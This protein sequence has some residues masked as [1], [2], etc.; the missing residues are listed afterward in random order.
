MPSLEVF[1]ISRFMI[2]TLVL[3][4]ISA[5]VMTA[6]LFGSQVLPRRVRALLA[7]A[8]SLLVTPVYL[9]TT[10]PPVE[11]ITQY[12]RLL[13]NEVLVGLLLG[14]GLNILFSGIQV[15]GQVVSQ[16][17]GLSLADVFNPGIEEDAS[18]FSQLFYFLTMAV[19]VAIGGH[20]ILTEA[21]LETFAAAPPGHA[22]LGAGFLDVLTGILTQSFA[23][24]ISA[25]APL[26][27]A[28][29]LS[30][31]ILGLVS[32]TLPQINVIAVGFGLNSLLAMGLLSVSLG[33]VAYTFQ[34]PTLD[35]LEKI[36]ATVGN[37]ATQ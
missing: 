37:V 9:G 24:G 29:L 23:L 25:A 26:L 7:V 18:V 5:V 27:V 16:M 35:V 8:L 12:G 22:V 13:V 4:R 17:S 10:L 28:L 1:L 21:L 34:E 11:Q 32:R 2:F 33:A 20:R 31:L 3:A 15:A 6:P 14:L 30:N 19:F 36:G